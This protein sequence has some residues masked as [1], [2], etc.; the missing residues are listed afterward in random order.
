[1]FVPAS[2]LLN[3]EEIERSTEALLFGA[4]AKKCD[5]IRMFISTVAGP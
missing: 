4:A 2:C 1:M 5:L 3:L